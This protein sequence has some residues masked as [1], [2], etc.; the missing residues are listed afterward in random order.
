MTKSNIYISSIE[1]RSATPADAR[2]ASRLL[3]DTF[4]Q[5]ATFIIGLGLEERAKKILAKLFTIEGHRLSYEF[6]KFAIYDGRVIGLVT[7]FPGRLHGRLNRKLDMVLL[8][9]YGLRGK[10]A[11]LKRGFPLVFIKETAKDEYFI[12]NFVTKAKMRSKGVGNLMLSGVEQWAKESGY[13]KVSL[14]V[15]IENRA[16][17]R[18]YQAHGFIPKAIHLETNKRVRYLGAGY[19][20]MVKILDQE[21]D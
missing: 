14:M 1:F 7:S 2:L 20:R 17:R 12:S 21:A 16:A 18:F 5:K 9:Q 3:F 13:R 15:H 19:Q 11:I 8:K 6:T 4:P 10:L